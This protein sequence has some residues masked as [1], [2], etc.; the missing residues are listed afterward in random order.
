MTEIHHWEPRENNQIFMKAKYKNLITFS[1][2]RMMD[3]SQFSFFFHE[4]K[5]GDRHF[6]CTKWGNHFLHSKPGSQKPL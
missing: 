6:L 2:F 3:L 4:T 1:R 5:T